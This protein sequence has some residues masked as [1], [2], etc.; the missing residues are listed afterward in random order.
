MQVAMLKLS[1]SIAQAKFDSAEI[2][3]YVSN[4]NNML[5]GVPQMIKFLLGNE[6]VNIK[7]AMNDGETQRIAYETRNAR[8]CNVVEGELKNPTISVAATE[9]ALKRI[10]ASSDPITTFQKERKLGRIAIRG[11]NA[12][13]AFKLD[14]ALAS[15]SVLR[16]FLG[17]FLS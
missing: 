15:T 7:I 1:V 12:A 4:Y 11:N 5:E 6:R 16:F 10:D 13:V 9:G 17:V 8:I 2:N 14:A 3:K